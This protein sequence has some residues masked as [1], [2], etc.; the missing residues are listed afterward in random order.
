MSRLF[1][2]LQSKEEAGHQSGS[3]DVTLDVSTVLS[4]LCS[5]SPDAAISP[6]TFAVHFQSSR[7]GGGSSLV[8]A[9]AAW[10][11]LPA[12]CKLEVTQFLCD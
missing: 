2:S 7:L 4:R 12:L 5:R 6:L 1:T 8:L 3:N 9:A 11:G 10:A